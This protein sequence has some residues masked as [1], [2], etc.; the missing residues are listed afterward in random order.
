MKTS[1]FTT[2]TVKRETVS[3]LR[4]RAGVVPMASFLKT[5]LER[6]EAHYELEVLRMSLLKQIDMLKEAI[7]EVAVAVQMIDFKTSSAYLDNSK[8]I[9]D[10]MA[11]LGMGLES[12]DKKAPGIKRA[13][14][15]Q[16]KAYS[17]EH[18]P[19]ELRRRF[20]QGKGKVEK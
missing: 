13:I 9:F 17:A 7:S 16:G 14:L 15:A 20:S 2:L 12:L 11:V 10:L 8:S 5:L 3:L 18:W 6:D 4:E 19:E 1:D